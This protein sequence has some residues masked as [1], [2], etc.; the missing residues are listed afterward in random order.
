MTARRTSSLLDL[1]P[2]L[3]QLLADD[4]RAT[5]RAQLQVEV[6]RLPAGPWSVDRM[7]GT[8]PE[9][10]GLL[11]LEGVISREVV[12][13]D[14]VSTEL[15][16]P[17]DVLRPW[18]LHGAEPLLQHQVRWNALTEAR[19]AVLDRRFGARLTHWP[20]VNSVLIDRLNDRAQRLATTQA[21]SQLNRV[22]RRLLALFWHL[23]ERWGRITSEGVAVPLTLSHRMLGQLVGARR[24]TV[25]T[26]IGDLA[27][28]DELIRRSDGTW[29]LK[30][31]PVGL[32]S[33]EAQ[34]IVPIRRRLIGRLFES[35][36]ADVAA[37]VGPVVLNEAGAPEAPQAEA[38][39]AAAARETTLVSAREELRATLARLRAES[40][41]QLDRL[42][43]TG[44]ESERV[45]DAVLA[46]R[47]RRQSARGA[48]GNGRD[49]HRPSAG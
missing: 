2:D 44:A 31:D 24:P 8:N 25:S 15:L 10:V 11:L 42:R 40:Q 26:A 22:D 3:G 37:R 36:E 47:E 1:D 4:R 19:V 23:A 6:H 27:R 29:L 39:T 13:A 33:E 20:E 21:I 32:P 28:R 9:H 16:G 41:E 43:S 7:A 12:V 34:R 30:G 45:R 18:A 14:T 46:A 48:H 17:G 38:A 5:A 49:G 35:E